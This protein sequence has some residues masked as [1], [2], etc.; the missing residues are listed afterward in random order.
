MNFSPRYRYVR[1]KAQKYYV[2]RGPIKTTVVEESKAVYS[3]SPKKI[4]VNINGKTTDGPD[5]IYI[6]KEDNKYK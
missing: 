3:K 1:G 2:T 6:W 4:K 5:G